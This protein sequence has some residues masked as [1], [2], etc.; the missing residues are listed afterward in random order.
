MVNCQEIIHFWLFI[1]KE[2]KKFLD[3]KLVYESS[4]TAFY[5]VYEFCSKILFVSVQATYC[6]TRVKN[7]N[8]QI[9]TGQ[10]TKTESFSFISTMWIG[11]VKCNN[12]LILLISKVTRIGEV[13]LVTHTLM[14]FS[15][16]LGWI[17]RKR[18]SRKTLYNSSNLWSPNLFWWNEFQCIL[19]SSSN[20]SLKL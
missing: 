5:L 3:F 1:W 11:L 4:K 18:R 13:A 10:Y 12:S 9:I 6:L 16:T 20:L 19:W 2:M 15:T 8:I 14:M 7:Q 17:L